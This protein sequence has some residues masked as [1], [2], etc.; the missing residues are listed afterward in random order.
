MSYRKVSRQVLNISKEYSTTTLGSLFQ[1]SVTL[2]VK[3]LFPHIHVELS[4][5]QFVSIA[6]FL[7]LG[8]T[9]K[10]LANP[11]DSHALHI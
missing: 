4:M 7:L 1:C 6:P 3:N 9:V 10:S 2:Q 5:S 11:F 8:T